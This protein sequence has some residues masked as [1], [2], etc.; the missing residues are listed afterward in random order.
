VYLRD[1]GRATGLRAAAARLQVDPVVER[2]G[3]ERWWDPAV[4]AGADLVV[5]T[6]PS[7]STD[8]IGPSLPDRVGGVLFD[9]VYD[10]WPTPLA[11][12]W[13]ERGG[14]V[15]GGLDLLVHQAVLQVA[16]MTGAPVDPSALL[17]RLRAAGERALR[18]G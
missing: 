4:L 8:A 10:P 13:T 11:R 1:P 15:V 6:T 14:H 7:G 9:V 12:A 16:L 3:D 18:R 17:P 5:A 2:A